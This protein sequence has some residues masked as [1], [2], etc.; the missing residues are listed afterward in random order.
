MFSLAEES[1][2]F[3]RRKTMHAGMFIPITKI[4]MRSRLIQHPLIHPKCIPLGA[5][6]RCY[7]FCCCLDASQKHVLVL[8]KMTPV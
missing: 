2:V 5:S 1:E 7:V 4:A 6:D 3:A 8:L